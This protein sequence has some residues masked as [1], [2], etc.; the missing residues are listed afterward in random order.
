MGMFPRDI[1]LI[2]NFHYYFFSGF[3]QHNF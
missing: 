3:F 1:I 2:I